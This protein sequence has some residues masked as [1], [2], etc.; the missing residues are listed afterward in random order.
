MISS[1]D[2]FWIKDN[3]QV[4]FS[5]DHTFDGTRPRFYINYNVYEDVDT[6]EMIAQKYK[7]FEKK[8]KKELPNIISLVL[9]ASKKSDII[10][11]IEKNCLGNWYYKINKYPNNHRGKYTAKYPVEYNFYFENES[12]AILYKLYWG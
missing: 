12:D 8:I 4:V 2:L 11:W 6:E 10:E 5:Y 3:N 7:E 1:S 9:C